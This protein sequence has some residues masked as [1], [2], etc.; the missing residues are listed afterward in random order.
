MNERIK[1]RLRE[2]QINNKEFAK[3]LNV[4]E[5][6]LSMILSGKRGVSV[7]LLIDIANKLNVTT[8]WL[9]FGKETVK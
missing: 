1:D 7:K 8:D 6:H 5:A 3:R 9:I 4:S 2:L